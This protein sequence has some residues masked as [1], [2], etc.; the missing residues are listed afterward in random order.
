MIVKCHRIV[1]G[2]AI[3]DAL[4]TIQPINFLT[5]LNPED[6][7][8]TDQNHELFGRSV[9]ST[10]LVFPN[11]IGSSVGAYIIYALR[12]SNAAPVAMVCTGKVDI[13]TASGCAISNIPLVT[14]LDEAMS[15]L[16]DSKVRIFVDANSGTLFVRKNKQHMNDHC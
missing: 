7:I 14:L 16:V 15:F 12:C 3:G 6:G 2:Q 13:I 10:V 11:A 9:K 4:T 8:I 5:M 1:G